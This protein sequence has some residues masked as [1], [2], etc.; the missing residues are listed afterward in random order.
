MTRLISI[1]I[2]AAVIFVG[3]RLYVY[4]ERVSAEKESAQVEQAI[5]PAKLSGLPPALEE[6]LRKAESGGDAEELGNWLRIYG[7]MV[8]D[9]RL[10]WIQLDYCVLLAR[11]SPNEA[12]QL[13]TS[14][15]DRTATNSPVY[16]RVK[17]LDNAFQ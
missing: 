11:S 3:Y 13:F 4:Y 16:P 6:S 15:K 2:I 5:D 8:Q 12:R 7:G 1:L 14:I 9:P 17:Q 10:A